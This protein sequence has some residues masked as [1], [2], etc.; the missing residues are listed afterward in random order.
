[1]VLQDKP[2]LWDA[3][4]SSSEVLGSVNVA[5]SHVFA[6]PR[7]PASS[8]QF[9]S[10]SLTFN[11][12]GPCS[13]LTPMVLIGAAFSQLSS[14]SSIRYASPSWSPARLFLRG[15]I[16]LRDS[17]CLSFVKTHAT[18]AAAMVAILPLTR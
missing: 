5:S 1:T 16:N 11:F 12:T 2:F 17:S 13:H 9:D 7:A 15:S 4:S 14:T 6:S 10:A 18:R 3:P 8:P